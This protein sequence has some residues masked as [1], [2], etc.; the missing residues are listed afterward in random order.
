MAEQLKC[1][2]SGTGDSAAAAYKWCNSIVRA[3][4]C[5]LRAKQQFPALPVAA[6]SRT[7]AASPLQ[8]P[9]VLYQG[10]DIVRLRRA[11]PRAG[12]DSKST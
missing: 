5:R 2:A 9:N 4:G 6:T 11:P 10:K 1:T 3:A 12:K 8:C 7:A